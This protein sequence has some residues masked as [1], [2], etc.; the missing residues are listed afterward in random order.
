MWP[1]ARSKFGALMFEREVIRKQ[2]YSIEESTCDIV[3]TFRHPGI[4]PSL[5]P[6][7]L[8]NNLPVSEKNALIVPV[9]F[10]V[11]DRKK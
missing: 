3:G 7:T 9:S 1:W 11:I 10:T 2:M 5:R 6:C 8:A 4:V